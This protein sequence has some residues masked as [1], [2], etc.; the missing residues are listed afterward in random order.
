[1]PIAE[2]SS[3]PKTNEDH[4]GHMNVVHVVLI[5]VGISGLQLGISD[6]GDEHPED[7]SSN[8]CQRG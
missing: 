2:S 6:I 3:A 4:D 1:M 7:C 5:D 8:D